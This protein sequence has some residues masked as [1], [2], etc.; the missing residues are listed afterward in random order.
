M[1]AQVEE[2]TRVLNAVADHVY[3]RWC[4]GLRRVA[5]GEAVSGTR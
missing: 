4:A 5:A 3:D 1:V 2:K